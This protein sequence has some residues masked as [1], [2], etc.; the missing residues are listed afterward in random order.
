VGL[1]QQKGRQSKRQVT[2]CGGGGLAPTQ[3]KGSQRHLALGSELA[4]G[5][6]APTPSVPTGGARA[7]SRSGQGQPNATW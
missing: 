1:T 6:A 4:Q 5:Q 3:G 7:N 2:P